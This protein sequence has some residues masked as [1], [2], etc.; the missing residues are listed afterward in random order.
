MKMCGEIKVKL[1]AFITSAL[2]KGNLSV[3]LFGCLSPVERVPST[4]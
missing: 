3:S 1:D 4:Y 2:N